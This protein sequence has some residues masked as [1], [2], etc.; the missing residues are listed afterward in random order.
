M[1][2]KLL[3]V[4]PNARVPTKGTSGSAYWDLYAA[5][6]FY[7][8]AGE[9]YPIST[10][11]RVEVPEGFFLDVRPRSGLA[12]KGLTVNNSPGTVDADF[13][14]ELKII[15]INHSGSHYLVSVGDRIAQC[16]IM[17][18]VPTEFSEA[19]ELS[20]APSRGKKGYGSTGK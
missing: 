13:R 10:G 16:A 14:G 15:F 4:S 3:R 8:G 9:V 18:V 19:A 17:P 7:L 2:V 20:E 5:E 1:F 6:T 12:T 11:W